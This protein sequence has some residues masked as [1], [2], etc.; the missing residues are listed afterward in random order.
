L[1][2]VALTNGSSSSDAVIQF[3]G[4]LGACAVASTAPT[5]LRTTGWP[6]AR[7]IP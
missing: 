2:N 4:T 7:V 6:S 1:P 3:S 5:H